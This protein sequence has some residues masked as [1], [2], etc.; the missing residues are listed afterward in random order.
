MSQKASGSFQITA[1]IN[2]SSI[3]GQLL[4]DNG[5]LYQ[6]IGANGSISP[7]W[8]D[9]TNKPTVYPVLHNLSD[10][11]ALSPVSY[12]FY[13]NGVKIEFDNDTKLSTNSAFEGTFKLLPSYSTTVNGTTLTVPAVEIEKDLVSASNTDNDIISCNGTIE[14]GGQSVAFNNLSRVITLQEVTG[15]SHYL[16]IEQDST[17][18]SDDV[19]TATL[20]AHYYKDGVEVTDLSTLGS[21]SITW[22]KVTG[23]GEEAFSPARTGK[24]CKIT[25]SDVDGSLTV[26]A[27]LKNGDLTVEGFA[28]VE[29]LADPYVIVFYDSDDNAIPDQL[30]PNES[31]TIKPKLVLRSDGSAYSGTV[32]YSW[33]LRANDGTY[34]TS[35]SVTATQAD[36]K[37]FTAN[38]VTLTYDKL[39]SVC[40]GGVSGYVTATAS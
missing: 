38:N 34:V 15:N 11:K 21:Y 40:G 5:P 13:Y 26:M 36:S 12:E 39:K 2:G 24:T 32:S 18:V 37:N 20:T 28:Q 19:T 16:W 6:T 35:A 3:Y 27:R 25:R 29:D 22:M 4:V 14:V 23:D 1:I 10:G 7:K 33:T 8:S 30:R 9:A 31:V 17:Y